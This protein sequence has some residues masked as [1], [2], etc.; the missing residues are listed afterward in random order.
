MSYLDFKKHFKTSSKGRVSGYFFISYLTRATQWIPFSRLNEMSTLTP[1]SLS[2][3]FM[4]GH[5]AFF[6]GSI[7]EQMSAFKMSE[8]KRF[9]SD[10]SFT[11]E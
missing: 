9:I 4:I 11:A 1:V 7:V 10:I 3:Y 8:D 5:L 6:M 2:V